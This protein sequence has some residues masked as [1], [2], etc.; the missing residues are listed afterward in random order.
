MNNE[1]NGNKDPMQ[2]VLAAIGVWAVHNCQG[3]ADRS[4]TLKGEK[5]DFLRMTTGNVNTS[6]KTSMS[7]AELEEFMLTGKIEPG[8][9]GQVLHLI[10]ETPTSIVE[11][12]VEQLA[13]KNNINAKLV[14]EN[15]ARVAAEIKSPNKFF[16]QRN[17]KIQ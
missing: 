4:I 5:M 1:N 12:A 9:E 11:G 6:Y 16:V 2:E 13:A 17:S 7:V 15:L 10:D 14:W 8:F 3:N